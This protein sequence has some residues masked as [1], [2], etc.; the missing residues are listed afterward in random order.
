MIE[1]R[2]E[3]A[4]DTIQNLEKRFQAARDEAG[5]RAYTKLAQEAI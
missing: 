5:S 4:D 2:L 1:Q 3:E